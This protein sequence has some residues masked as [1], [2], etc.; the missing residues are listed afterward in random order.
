MP[1][2]GLTIRKFWGIVGLFFLLFI[3]TLLICPMI[4]PEKMSLARALDTSLSIDKNPD[5]AIL[6]HVRL[7]RCL[8]AA[9]VGAALAAAGVTF[10]SMLKNP[11]ATPYTLGISGGS[12]LAAVI[13]LVYAGSLSLRI[14]FLQP[15]AAFGGAVLTLWLVYKLGRR[16]GILQNVTLILA[17][18]TL[19]LFF[20]AT[21][22]LIQFL[23][24]PSQ[25]VLIMHWLMGSLDIDRYEPILMIIP[26][27]IAGIAILLYH[28][29]DMNLLSL[30]EMSAQSLGLRV[31]AVMKRL[32][33][34][35]SL[36]AGTAIAFSGPIGFVGLIIPHALRL[37][38]GADHRL[39][40]PV[41]YLA[42]G[43]FLV[44]CDTAARTLLAPTELPV[45]VITALL[46]GPFFL[47]L[48]IRPKSGGGI[49]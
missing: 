30:D 36:I 31:P 5:A 12:S 2:K 27:Q 23:V 18:V 4:G 38:L 41:S 9:I 13:I 3:V 26:F 45:G 35:S 28:A 10:Q 20:G 48:L 19:N 43:A 8:M 22:L 21:I 6:F 29:R 46:G 24:D 16:R 39:L 37:V 32:Y 17:G 11:L 25:T 40:L 49:T 1:L 7:P 42:G 47:A 33:I 34:S 15:L 14:P 44:I